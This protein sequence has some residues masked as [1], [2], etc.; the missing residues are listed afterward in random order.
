MCLNAL[1][2]GIAQTDTAVVQNMRMLPLRLFD[3][4][5]GLFYPRFQSFLLP[6]LRSIAAVFPKSAMAVFADHWVPQHACHNHIAHSHAPAGQQCSQ[7]QASSRYSPLHPWF[8]PQ[9]KLSDSSL[10]L[11]TC[12]NLHER[13]SQLPRRTLL[14]P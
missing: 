6:G 1:A 3:L 4:S 9:G 7:P 12:L 8:H 14:H 13:T 10:E 11:M 2:Q 5:T